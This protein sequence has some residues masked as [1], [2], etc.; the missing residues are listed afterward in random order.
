M[1]LQDA[2][3]HFGSHPSLE[4]FTSDLLLMISDRSSHASVVQ[5]SIFNEGDCV[6]AFMADDPRTPA[7]LVDLVRR[8]DPSRLVDVN[9]GGPANGH[10]LGDVNDVHDYGGYLGS[11]PHPRDPKPNATQ[12][13][14]VGEFGGLGAFVTEWQAGKCRSNSP[15]GQYG[16]GNSTPAEQAAGYVA[17]TKLLAANR[18]DISASV[19]TQI[20]DVETE[21]DGMLTYDRRS[22][23][24][25]ADTRR[26]REANAA[27]ILG[28]R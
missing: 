15:A 23:F 20:A 24:G 25:A 1:I 8:A 28:A 18:R 5:W 27:L 21:C 14:M 7:D 9:S 22:K 13:A 6:K 12:Y 17:M 11:N 10:N 19:Y 16:H 26:I 2:V 4:L 3:Q